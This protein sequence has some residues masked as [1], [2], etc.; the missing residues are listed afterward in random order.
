MVVVRSCDAIAES[1]QPDFQLS[2]SQTIIKSFHKKV[3]IVFCKG[4][5]QDGRMVGLFHGRLE[6]NQINDRSITSTELTTILMMELKR[7]YPSCHWLPYH[8]DYKLL[9]NY[10]TTRNVGHALNVASSNWF[11]RRAEFS[12]HSTRTKGANEMEAFAKLGSCFALAGASIKR[13]PATFFFFFCCIFRSN[14]ASTRS[15]FLLAIY[16]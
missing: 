6:S 16:K 15:F 14:A 2:S 12:K 3:K 13:G 9:K 11:F 1:R 4:F 8:N 10:R 5:L 7:C